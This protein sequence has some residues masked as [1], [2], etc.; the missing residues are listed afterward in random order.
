[1]CAKPSA[2]LSFVS[3]FEAREGFAEAWGLKY[4]GCGA[5]AFFFMDEAFLENLQPWALDLTC[6]QFRDAPGFA[7]L[8]G[9]VAVRFSQGVRRKGSHHA[10]HV[11]HNR[12][13]MFSIVDA[14]IIFLQE[15]FASFVVIF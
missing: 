12:N 8:G 7:Q 11:L 13:C 4:S 15:R 9:P 3:F 1:M 14:S 10:V 5:S 2:C 6:G